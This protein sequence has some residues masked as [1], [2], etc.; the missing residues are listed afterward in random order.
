MKSV[1]QLFTTIVI[2]LCSSLFSISAKA[3]N[4]K[5]VWNATIHM[6]A[7][8][9]ESTSESW[10]LAIL[11]VTEDKK[12]TFKIIVHHMDEGD[13]LSNAHIHYGAP[14]VNGSPFIPMMAG[15]MNLGKNVTVQLTDQQY[16]EL[17][18]GTQPIYINV[19]SHIYPGDSIRGQ[20]RE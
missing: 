10:G 17:V 7:T 4:G 9:A 18:N 2:I 5:V 16:E 19:H 12:L 3:Q 20:I 15:V 14:G 6:D 8:Q 13:E 1:T 11:R